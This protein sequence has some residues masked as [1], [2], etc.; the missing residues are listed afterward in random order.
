MSVSFEFMTN[1]WEYYSQLTPK[2]FACFR[3]RLIWRVVAE[4]ERQRLRTGKITGLIRQR[5]HRTCYC[6]MAASCVIPHGG[7]DYA[8][9]YSRIKR[10]TSSTIWRLPT[11]NERRW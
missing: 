8:S 3:F 1:K 10:S 7:K 6:P 2:V 4:H 5:R 11:K 9:G